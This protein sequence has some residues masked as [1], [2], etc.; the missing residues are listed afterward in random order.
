LVL[1]LPV[2]RVIQSEVKYHHPNQWSG[3][4]QPS[5][6]ARSPVFRRCPRLFFL[7]VIQER[8]GGICFCRC[9]CSCSCPSFTLAFAHTKPST[10]NSVI[11]S[12]AQR[13]RRICS[14]RWS[15]RCPFHAVILN[16]MKNPVF[17][18]CPCLFFFGLSFRSEAEESAVRSNP[19]VHW[20]LDLASSNKTALGDVLL[21]STFW[22][23]KRFSTR[24]SRKCRFR[25]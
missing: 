7:V 19:H 17:R 6:P 2:L 24:D 15:C 9:S 23:R 20:V 8:S 4:V 22:R 21:R 25:Q 10:P 16:E 12:E 18:R 5:V 13:S 3:P 14:C 11:L 1:P